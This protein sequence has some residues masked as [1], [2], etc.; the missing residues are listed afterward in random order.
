MKKIE[1]IIRPFKL[2]DVKEA[3]NGVGVMAMTVGEVQGSGGEPGRTDTY[4]GLEYRVDVRPRVKVEV[5]VADCR[6][7]Q[8]SWVITKAARTGSPGAGVIFV[9]SLDDSIRIRTGERGEAPSE[10]S[11]HPSTSRRPLR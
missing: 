9:S 6:A 11:P 3:L 10:R 1:A 8:V 7:D 2:G 4:R 5:V